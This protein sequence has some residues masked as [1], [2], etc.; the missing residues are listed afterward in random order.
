METPNWCQQLFE[1]IDAMDA[2]GFV[3]F[4][5]DDAQF[6]FGNAQEVT[7]KEKIRE[8]IAGFF[9]SIKG[10]RHHILRTWVHPEAVICQG[11]VTYTRTDD[12]QITIPFVNLFSMEGDYINHYHIYIDI[13][14]LHRPFSGRR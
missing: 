4:L 8:A 1:R 2:D 11:E 14:P 6:R 5:T 3:S 12:S 9:A 7:G 10:L 13:T